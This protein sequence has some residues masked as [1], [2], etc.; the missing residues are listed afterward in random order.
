MN[1]VSEEFKL[2]IEELVEK[3]TAGDNVAAACLGAMALLADGWRY[4]DPDPSA[5][6]NGGG[7]VINLSDYLRGKAA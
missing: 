2:L 7:E 5:P 3:A 6:P 1:K 4:G